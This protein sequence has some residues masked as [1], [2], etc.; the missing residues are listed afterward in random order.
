MVMNAK[1][2]FDVVIRNGLVADGTGKEPFTADIAV[3]GDSIVAVGKLSGSGQEEIDASGYLVTPG[4]VDI[5]THYD[6]QAIWSHYL[7][8][9]SCHGV[10]TVVMGNCGV[11]FAPCRGKDH[12]LLINAME[13]VEDVPEVVM[14]EGLTW[15]W[16]TFPDYL[17]ALE[18]RQLDINCGAYIPHS[19]LRVFVMG[20]RGANREPATKNDLDR[21]VALTEEAMAAGAMGFATSR[22]Y[23]HRRADGDFI[24][25]YQADEQELRAI[26]EAV[27]K[28]GRGIIQ[29]VTDI[30]MSEEV[31]A[32]ADLDLMTRISKASGRPVSFTM[33]QLDEH[34]GRWRTILDWVE[35]ANA[36]DGV[37]LV[38]QVFPRPVGMIVGHDLS[39]NPF[40]LTPTYQSLAKL[41][42]EP[43]IEA[44]RTPDVKAKI[45]GEAPINSKLP[46]MLLARQFD[47][48]FTIT[49]P[50]DYEPDPAT[51]IAARAETMGISPEELAYNLMLED[52][53]RSMLF[54]AL[55]NFSTGC[56]DPALAM[57]KHPSTV[58]GLGDGGAHYGLICDASYP[59]F[60][61]AHWTRDRKGEKL[62]LAEAVKTLSA[63]TARLVGLDDRG[64]IAP[65]KKADLNIIDYYRLHLH[66]PHVTYDLP[67]G[68][69]RLNQSAT[70]Y[71]WTFVNGKPIVRD[72]EQ[73][74][75]L[76]G[77][78]VRNAVTADH[79]PR[80]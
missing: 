66:R 37:E 28:S 23:G 51:S 54:V 46:L 76:P 3:T 45:L 79:G 17:E 20:E 78:L 58:V 24:P 10:T 65:G 22:I 67:A 55:T 19:A 39:T 64:V 26:A 71:L 16:E 52:D 6:G 57:M 2:Q 41:P 30:S 74:G 1:T 56:L 61:L 9:S 8:P 13:G 33:V 75:I 29:A 36:R 15:D 68:G 70:G 31:E 11:G 35:E 18:K 12:D 7:T 40:A 50:P 4:F 80:L 48:M 59:T 43:R 44:L 60:V 69:R 63:D 62:S 25:S 32:R 72:D 73:T 42:L 34:P 77:V 27:G 49:D 47:R 14:A 38:P 21:M 5:H 53:G